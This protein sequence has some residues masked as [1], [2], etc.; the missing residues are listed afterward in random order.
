MRRRKGLKVLHPGF[1][2]AF[3]LERKHDITFCRQGQNL[4]R[5]FLKESPF[6]FELHPY[7]DLEV[8]I[9]SAPSTS[10]FKV[11]GNRC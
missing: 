8:R 1:R 9:I 4:W 10:G 2:E 7:L 3:P 11:L 6:S 5:D